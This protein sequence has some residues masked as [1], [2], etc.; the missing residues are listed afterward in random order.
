MPIRGRTLAFSGLIVALT[1]VPA[2]GNGHA[3]STDAGG[4]IDGGPTSDGQPGDDGRDGETSQPAVDGPTADLLGDVKDAAADGSVIDASRTVATS[5]DWGMFNEGTL[6]V[7]MRASGGSTVPTRRA[8]AAG[9][10]ARTGLA[11]ASAS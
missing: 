2:C 5:C 11:P 7:L 10:P 4:L 3:S 6:T 1:H 9:E 8:V